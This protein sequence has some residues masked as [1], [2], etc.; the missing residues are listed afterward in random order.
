MNKNFPA[1]LFFIGFLV[2][3][4]FLLPFMPGIISGPIFRMAGFEDQASRAYGRSLSPSSSTRTLETLEQIGSSKC[5]PYVKEIIENAKT[6]DS[7]IK[8]SIYLLCSLGSSEANDALYN[9]ISTKNIPA[10]IHIIY[11]ITHFKGKRISSA[12]LRKEEPEHPLSRKEFQDFLISSISSPT[13]E[14]SS[15]AAFNARFA[16]STPGIA[17]A[18]LDKILKETDEPDVNDILSL[19]FLPNAQ[20]TSDALASRIRKTTDSE[21]KEMLLDALLGTHLPE[22]FKTMLELAADYRINKSL[23]FKAAWRLPLFSQEA[24][25]A[26]DHANLLQLEKV[27]GFLKTRSPSERK[28]GSDHYRGS[29]SSPGSDLLDVLEEQIIRIKNRLG[30][31]NADQLNSMLLSGRKSQIVSA[32]EIIY[33]K[34]MAGT[35][36]SVMKLVSKATKP[37]FPYF[38]PSLLALGALSPDEARKAAASVLTNPYINLSAIKVI[39]SLGKWD[40]SSD[41]RIVSKLKELANDRNDAVTSG[42]ARKALADIGAN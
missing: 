3:F 20:D 13:E 42:A 8:E 12:R 26:A 4:I 24:E 30:D 17:S 40:F 5:V 19:R 32:L 33:K 38:V 34:P 37:D 27:S 10:Y 1:I 16:D 22:A 41:D 31:I 36:P 9:Q 39:G 28:V 18:I 15:A 7:L 2:I 25:A 21:Q 29:F 14:I 11:G 6:N 35:K 23:A